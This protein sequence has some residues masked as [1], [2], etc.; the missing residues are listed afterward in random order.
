MVLEAEINKERRSGIQ[1][2]VCRWIMKRFL[3][4]LLLLILT[5]GIVITVMILTGGL[6]IGGLFNPPINREKAE[7]ALLKDYEE[8]C[9]IVDYMKNSEYADIIIQSNDYVYNDENYGTWHIYDDTLKNNEAGNKKIKD[10]NI[11]DILDVLFKKKN[12]HNISKNGN[13]ISFLLWSNLDA[14]RGLAY[15]IDGSTPSLQFLTKIEK[16]DKDNW[17]YYEEDFNEWKRRNEK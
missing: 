5:I 6:M 9:I 14:G 8:V 17:Y 11:V 16:L 2:I 10:K 12:Y 13:T 3:K 4:I 1:K 7:K 15:T